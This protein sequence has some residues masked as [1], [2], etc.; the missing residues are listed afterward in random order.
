MASAGLVK[1]HREMAASGTFQHGIKVALLEYQG[2]LCRGAN[3]GNTAAANHFK[4]VGALEFA[5][6]LKT[7]AESPRI[8]APILDRDNLKHAN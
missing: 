6:L 1:Q 5:N 8:P 4:A 7:L 2:L 3:D